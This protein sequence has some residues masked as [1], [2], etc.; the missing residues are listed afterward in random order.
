MTARHLASGE[1]SSSMLPD[2]PSAPVVVIVGHRGRRSG[3][4]RDRAGDAATSSRRSRSRRRRRPG[5]AAVRRRTVRSSRSRSSS[6][7]SSRAARCSSPASSSASAS[8][9]SRARRRPSRPASSR[10][11][12]A[13]TRSSGASPAATSTSRASIRRRD[14][15]HGRL[16]RR[17][18]LGLPDARGVPVRACRTCPASS[19]GS[20]P[21]SGRVRRQGRRRPTARRSAPTASSSSSAPIDGSP[22][23]EGRPHR[24]RRDRRDRRRE[25]RRPDRRRGPRQGPRQEGHRGRP[26]DRPRQRRPDRRPDRPRRHRPEGGHHEGPR[27]RHRRLHRTSPASR[28]TPRAQ[29]HDALQADLKAGKKKIILDLRGNPGGYVTAA[30][31]DRQRVHRLRADLLGAG[32]RRRPDRDRRD[33]RAASRPPTIQLVVLVD[34]GS[35]SASEIVA[36]ALQDRKRAQ[37]VGETSFGKGTVQQWIELQDGWRAQADDREVA[38]AGQALDPPRRA[39]SPDVPVATPAARRPDQDPAL[40]KAV[41]IADG[42]RRPTAPLTRPHVVTHEPVLRAARPSGTVFGE[43]KEVMCSDRQYE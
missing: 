38:D 10:S 37:L 42:R 34:K 26:D 36:G 27:R 28:T 35:A 12:T 13:T 40:D 19:R 31:A 9:T 30:R 32:R 4:A 25:P 18:V 29:F 2:R 3:R 39:S 33:R 21:R 24:R 17:P 22:A 1:P 8:P 23:A 41:E 20:A 7:R 16:A 11:G 6:S 43:R 15:G 5:R 14:Q